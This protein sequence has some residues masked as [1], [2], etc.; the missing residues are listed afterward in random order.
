MTGTYIYFQSNSTNYVASHLATKQNIV[1]F[2]DKE[3]TLFYKI[4]Y[5]VGT[6]IAQMNDL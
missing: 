5:P 6:F 2:F 4:L 1:G 3:N